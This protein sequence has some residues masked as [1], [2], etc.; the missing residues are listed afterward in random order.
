[1]GIPLKPKETK[2]VRF[3]VPAKELGYWDVDKKAFF[4]EP[5]EFDVMVGSSSNEIKQVGLFKVVGK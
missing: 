4:V 2:S 5:R 3:F 1:M